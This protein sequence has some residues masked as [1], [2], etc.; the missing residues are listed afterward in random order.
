[1]QIGRATEREPHGLAAVGHA[2]RLEHVHAAFR[3][4]CRQLPEL[5][6][7]RGRRH[8][9]KQQAQSL[10]LVRN[11]VAPHV[12]KGAL[13][14]RPRARRGAMRRALRAVRIVKLQH[15]RLHEGV[16]AAFRY[17]MVGIAVELGRPTCIS[18]GQHRLRITLEANRRGVITRHAGRELFGLVDIGQRQVGALL[19]AAG[20]AGEQQR[21]SHDLE[22]FAP[23]AHR[24]DRGRLG[25]LGFEPGAKPAVVDDFLQTRPEPLA[26]GASEP[27]P[28]FRNIEM[29]CAG[30]R[31]HT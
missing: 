22:E 12:G 29:R 27:A 4:H 28:D 30:H 24:H 8:V 17:R 20:Q 31:W 23:P 11:P 2:A 7:Q 10:A 1:M 5:A 15:G 16:A 19:A 18:R 13:E 6:H 14:R 21:R 25:K 9:A 26:G 3:Q